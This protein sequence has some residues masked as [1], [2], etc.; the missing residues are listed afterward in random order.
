MGSIPWKGERPH[1]GLLLHIGGKA[2]ELDS[3]ITAA[4]IPGLKGDSAADDDS[5]VEVEDTTVQ[6]EVPQARVPSKFVGVAPS[7]FYAAVKPK[8]KG[9]LCVCSILYNISDP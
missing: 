8:P 7:S 4:Q 6:P 5:V 9:P 2:V 1:S 3:K